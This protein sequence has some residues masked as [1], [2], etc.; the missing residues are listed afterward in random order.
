MKGIILAAGKGTRLYPMTIP[1]SKQLMPIYDKP[2]IYYPIS[3]LLLAGIKEIL[4]I[5]TEKDMPLFKELLG[6]GSKIG[7]KFEYAIQNE[8]NGIGEAFIIGEDF[9]G[10]DDVMLIL[11]DNM[12]Y[13]MGLSTLL[14]DAINNNKDGATVFAYQVSNP[15]DFGIVNFDE[16]DNIVSIEEKPQNPTSNYA[17]PGLYIYDNT[18]VQKA[19]ELTPSAR[20]EK[21]ITDINKK[22]LSEGKLKLNKLWRGFAWLDTGTPE[23]LLNA[24]TFVETLQKR[25]GLQVSCIEEIAWRKGFITD[26]Q[27]EA[28]GNELSKTDYGKYILNLLKQR[29]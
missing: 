28:I 6:D 25:Q 16:N 20:G 8:P 13:G 24:S 23:G 3:T 19:K 29:S 12:F 4:I 27:F 11:G 22:Y 9:I 26:T 18:V 17:I 2:L 7:I 15:Q 1:F 14:Q 5:A 21:E 10:K